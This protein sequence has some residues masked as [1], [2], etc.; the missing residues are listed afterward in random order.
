[1]NRIHYLHNSVQDF[2]FSNI[3]MNLRKI[4][5]LI[6]RATTLEKR[7]RYII[8]PT[9]QTLKN[10]GTNRHRLSSLIIRLAISDT[11]AGTRK[12]TATQITNL[13]FMTSN[14]VRL[15]SIENASLSTG[16]QSGWHFPWQPRLVA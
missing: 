14:Q 8:L 1:M 12:V 11:V 7:T 2:E 5:N 6:L 13:G 15:S 16:T 4:L 10:A 9:H 3:V